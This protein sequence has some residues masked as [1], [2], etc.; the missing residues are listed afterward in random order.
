MNNKGIK[1]KKFWR[2]FGLGFAFFGI[3][4]VMSQLIGAII[5]A[6]YQIGYIM[7]E[8]LDLQ[9][10][11]TDIFAIAAE[12]MNSIPGLGTATVIGLI[13][14]SVLAIPS[15]PLFYKLIKVN[16]V[17]YPAIPSL[18]P[19]KIKPLTIVLSVVAG[20]GLIAFADAALS[21]L[22][23]PEAMYEQFGNAFSFTDSTPRWLLLLGIGIFGPVAEELALR[24]GIFS[25]MRRDSNFWAAALMSSLLFGLMHGIPLQICYATVFGLL[26]AAVFQLTKSIWPCI[27]IHIVNNSWSFVM[28]ESAAESIENFLIG[29]S[30]AWITMAIG[31]AMLA[32]S[33]YFMARLQKDSKWQ[34]S[35]E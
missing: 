27:I 3:F 26:F 33:I 32:G 11:G 14:G 1:T 20:L 6:V 5:P 19:G 12:M 21:L 22:P 13:V 2:G 29:G 35:Y 7:R 8:G 9:F 28:P 15:I 18:E 4:L 31:A 25:V 34:V 23:I 30:Q 17:K 24:S 10:S 16:R